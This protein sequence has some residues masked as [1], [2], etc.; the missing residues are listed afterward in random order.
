MSRDESIPWLRAATI[1]ICALATTLMSSLF[2]TTS[3]YATCTT[4]ATFNFGRVPVGYSASLS[5]D[6][7]IGIPVGATA[8]VSSLDFGGAGQDYSVDETKCPSGDNNPPCAGF[9]ITSTSPTCCATI[10]VNPTQPGTFPAA[11]LTA[12]TLATDDGV[13]ESACATSP[14]TG[15][16]GIIVTPPQIPAGQPVPSTNIFPLAS[17]TPNATQPGSASIPFMAANI[18]GTIDWTTTTDYVTHGK[19]AVPASTASF[20]TTMPNQVVTQPYTEVGG[21][22][23]V[24]ATAQGYTDTAIAYIVGAQIDDSTITSV[25]GGFSAPCTSNLFDLIA[26]YESGHKQ[27][28]YSEDLA[29]PQPPLYGVDEPWPIESQQTK[30]SKH[31]VLNKVGHNIGL[32][33]PQ[34]IGN[35]FED[36]MPTAWDWLLNAQAAYDIFQQHEGYVATAVSAESGKGSPSSLQLEEMDLFQYSGRMSG[37]LTD[38][39]VQLYAPVCNGK[40]QKFQKKTGLCQACSGTWQWA[41]NPNKIKTVHNSVRSGTAYLQ[42][43]YKTLP[44]TCS[45]G[46]K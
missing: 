25:L 44:V 18:T 22:M 41:L 31:Q 11:T 36:P 35:G 38:P 28:G 23:M 10:T 29:P 1:I 21:Q 9:T 15:L 16:G 13:T 33:Q 17:P 20:T 7:T 4:S 26:T 14:L 2:S 39:S 37:S 8:Y 43:I 32:M 40:C 34:L 42:G 46:N 5:D 24:T 30:N 27:F 6:I 19:I 45:N 3:A 12:T